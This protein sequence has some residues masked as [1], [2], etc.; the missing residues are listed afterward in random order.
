[1]AGGCRPSAIVR[2]FGLALP[3]ARSLRIGVELRRLHLQI[4]GQSRNAAAVHLQEG[5]EVGALTE[6]QPDALHIDVGDDRMTVG[7]LAHP[8]ANLD[9]RL[10]LGSVRIDQ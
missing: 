2:Y 9:G 3:R 1:M 10:A 7:R 4:I 8:E 6:S 5:R